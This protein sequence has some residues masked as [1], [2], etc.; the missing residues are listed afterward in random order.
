MSYKTGERTGWRCEWIS[1]EHRSWGEDLYLCDLDF[2]CVEYYSLEP[3][4]FV[5]YKHIK[6]FENIHWKSS[7][8]TVLSKVATRADLP[9]VI[10]VYNPRGKPDPTFDLYPYNKIAQDYYGTKPVHYNRRDYVGMLYELRGFKMNEYLKK[11]LDNLPPPQE[12][13]EYPTSSEKSE[14]FF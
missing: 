7:G 11:R 5:D 1:K 10:T 13:K 14:S 12:E 4:L 8:L 3:T 9:F 2:C 6:G